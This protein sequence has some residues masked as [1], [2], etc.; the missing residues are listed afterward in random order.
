MPKNVYLTNDR[1]GSALWTRKPYWDTDWE[2]W[3]HPDD[4]EPTEGR[5]VDAL[6]SILSVECGEICKLVEGE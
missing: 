3:L 4:D 2:A 1:V 6:V 5:A